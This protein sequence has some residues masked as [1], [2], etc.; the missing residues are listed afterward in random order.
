MPGVMPRELEA[1][2]FA[3][4]VAHR[5][6]VVDAGEVAIAV[7]VDVP[8]RKLAALERRCIRR[9]HP[10]EDLGVTVSSSLGRRSNGPV[11]A[12]AQMISCAA[13]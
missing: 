10:A 6:A 12:P 8:N 11:H 4:V 7:G 5:E 1:A 13:V 3:G 9:A 2:A